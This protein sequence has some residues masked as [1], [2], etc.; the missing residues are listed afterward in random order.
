[1]LIDGRTRARARRHLAQSDPVMARIVGKVGPCRFQVDRGGGPFASLCESIVYQQ[2]TGHA[3][4]AIFERLRT[5]VGRRH[6]RPQD[7]ARLSDA[8]LRG[9]GLSRQK[10]GYLRDLTARA[11]D[12]LPLHRVHRMDDEAAIETL[13]AV[14]GIGR[15]TAQMY[16]MFRLGR[17]DLMPV[18]DYGVR[19][20]MQT[21]WRMRKLPKPDRMLR[22]AEPWRPYRSVAAWYLWRSLDQ[23]LL[24]ED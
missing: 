16:L 15:W 13:S 21:A 23:K 17:L 9:V 3:A 7:I 11:Q 18:D 6:A 5:K 8:D 12:G 20:A 14:R 22:L 1:M 19:K 10:I 24:G 4:V 2:I